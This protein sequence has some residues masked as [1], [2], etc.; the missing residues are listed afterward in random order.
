LQS[1]VAVLLLLWGSQLISSAWDYRERRVESVETWVGERWF[2]PKGKLDHDAKYDVVFGKGVI[3]LTALKD[4]A[5]DVT[6]S[7]GALFGSAIVKVDPAIAYDVQVDETFGTVRTPKRA[8]VNEDGAYSSPTTHQPRL[9][10]HLSSTFGSC[11]LVEVA[12]S[13]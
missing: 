2:A 9:H 7:V 4:P 13:A 8:H 1:V 11:K 3:D 5:E 12:A 10:L 6:V